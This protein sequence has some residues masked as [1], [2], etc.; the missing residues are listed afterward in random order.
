[1]SSEIAPLPDRASLWR[2]FVTVLF[3]PQRTME[4]VL[5]R[6]GRAVIPLLVLGVLSDSLKQGSFSGLRGHWHTLP[7]WAFVVVPIGIAVGCAVIVLLVYALA[8]AVRTIATLLLDGDGPLR[9][10]VAALAWGLTPMVWAL[11]YRLPLALFSNTFIPLQTR[12]GQAQIEIPDFA[13]AGCGAALALFVLELAVLSWTIVVTGGT[14]SAA[15]KIS[16]IRALGAL[17]MTLAVPI[18]VVVAALLASR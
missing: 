10:V 17:A 8:F 9:D 7:P 15:L 6:P 2:D 3:R 1:M 14:L 4:R 18:V 12:I 16:P 11:L 5:A 13:A